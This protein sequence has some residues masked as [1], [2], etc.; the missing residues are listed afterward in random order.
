[1][2]RADL[3]AM[4][5]A[6]DATDW[7]ALPPFFH[8]EM[9]YD[10]PGFPLLNGREAVLDFYRRIRAIRGEH[11][12]EAFVIEG[13]AGASWGRFVGARTDGTPVD[14][15]F[16]DCY[17]FKDGAIWRRQSYFYVPLV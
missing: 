1:M 6:I 8:P 12:F 2:T 4:F 7:D 15:A 9:T 5:R 16:A 3:E 14:I 17:R 10:R 11:R 13:D